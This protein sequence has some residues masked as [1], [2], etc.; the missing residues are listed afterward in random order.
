MK[1]TLYPRLQSLRCTEELSPRRCYKGKENRGT[2][3]VDSPA[4]PENESVK[5]VRFV[6]QKGKIIQ[7]QVITTLRFS[8][9]FPLLADEVNG[10]I[11]S[12][13]DPCVTRLV[14][15]E[16]R[17]ITYFHAFY[18]IISRL[19][20]GLGKDHCQSVYQRYLSYDP[21]KVLSH[22]DKLQLL[23]QDQ[24]KRLFVLVGED[25]AGYLLKQ[26]A[27]RSGFHEAQF[28]AIERWIEDYNLISLLIVHN[29]SNALIGR[30][31]ENQF[32][33]QNFNIANLATALRQA[34][35]V[36]F[37]LS[38]IG[39]T[40]FLSR[41]LTEVP[42]EITTFT[43]LRD[44]YLDTG[45]MLTLSP[46][47]TRIKT[48]EKLFVCNSQVR[49]IPQ[50]IGQLTQLRQLFLGGNNLTKLPKEIKELTKME[51]LDISH[52]QFTKVPN[53]IQF[54][55]RL[56]TLVLSE[57]RLRRL[58]S[59]LGQLKNLRELDLVG[60]QVTSLPTELFDIK[61]LRI[62]LSISRHANALQHA[63]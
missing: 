29:H 2:K 51:V 22:Q 12:F 1:I 27:P 13:V 28:L 8:N 50:E 62:S 5:K 32:R 57:N 4:E 38:P 59:F 10:L 46:V 54:L 26:L 55:N 23:V 41:N 20:N 6:I 63:E 61:T 14:C 31:L 43:C 9:Y 44:L 3:R 39:N 15:K 45:R 53:E 33:L 19:E 40:I 52:N 60:T 42:K 21:E 58:P 24:R 30:K 16:W 7:R 34:S 11:F 25:Y 56:E 47:V 49:V 36:N 48:L 35:K 18:F 37:Y 17:K